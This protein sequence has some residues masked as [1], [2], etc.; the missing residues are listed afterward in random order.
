MKLNLNNKSILAI[1]LIIALGC[2][3]ALLILSGGKP[4]IAD[5]HG[6]HAEKTSHA[7]HGSKSTAHAKEHAHED[8]AHKDHTEK[9]HD[10]ETPS[11]KGPHGGKLFTKDGYGLE[12]TMVDQNSPPHFRVY[13]YQNGKPLPPSAS[14]IALNL[15]RLGKAAQPLQLAAE[16]DYLKSNVE[17]EEPHSFKVSIQAQHAGKTYQFSYEQIEGRIQMNGAT[18]KQQGV[19]LSSAGPRKLLSNLAFLGEV[20]L[21]EDRMLQIVPRLNGVVESVAVSAG[22]KVSKGQVLAVILSQSLV[23]MRSEVMAAQKRHALARSNF[24]R[25]KKLWEEKI[26]AQQDYLQANTSM[27]EAAIALQSAEQKLAAIGAGMA[28]DGKL[29]RY[30]IRSPIAGTITDKRISIGQALKDDTAIFTVADLSSVWVE[31]AIPAKDLNQIKLGQNAK[32]SANAFEASAEGKLSYIGA[33]MG[34]QTRSAKARVVLPNP[35]RTWHPG[36][37]VSVALLSDGSEAAIAV[38]NDAIQ[39]INQRPTIFASVGDA[40]EARPIELGRSD[41]QFTELRKGLQAGDVYVS[42]NSFLIKAEAGQIRRWPRPLT[43]C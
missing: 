5:E 20:K 7:E 28:S 43:A 36:L 2:I 6:A 11:A 42:K 31:L 3:F 18:R 29:N 35:A 37:T 9:D 25:E 34:E 33:V 15:E 39:T 26:S 19:E 13:A 24:A 23:D 41:G 16:N 8:H 30:E 21:N 38:A 22:D 4:A 14:N 1:A 17:I 27:Q 12:V 10:D 40:I 32:I